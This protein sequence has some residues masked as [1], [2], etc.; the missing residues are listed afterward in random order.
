MMNGQNQKKNRK[1][2]TK[3]FIFILITLKI[4]IIIIATINMERQSTHR[5]KK[6]IKDIGNSLFVSHR[7]VFCF[8]SPVQLLWHFFPVFVVVVVNLALI[9]YYYFLSA[10]SFLF[11]S[12]NE[13]IHATT[14]KNETKTEFYQNKSWIRFFYFTLLLFPTRNVVSIYTTNQPTKHW[15]MTVTEKKSWKKRLRYSLGFCLW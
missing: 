6:K 12:R 3:N 11:I 8:Y 10:F 1:Q 5:T 14:K 2:E 4:I 7:I 13:K 15:S 9:F